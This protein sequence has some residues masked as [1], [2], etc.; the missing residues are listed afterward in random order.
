LTLPLS[1]RPDALHLMADEFR[2]PALKNHREEARNHRDDHLAGPLQK[3]GRGNRSMEKESFLS[4]W[5]SREK[6]R[7]RPSA[8]RD[9]GEK[10]N[11]I[12]K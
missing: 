12:E 3:E 10:D 2:N 5:E 8:D 1:E 11:C 6:G 7:Q 9:R 4:R